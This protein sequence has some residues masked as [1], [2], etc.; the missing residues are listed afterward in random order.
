[1]KNILSGLKKKISLLYSKNK[2]LFTIIIA[3]FLVIIVCL[4]FY[5]KSSSKINDD[6]NQNVNSSCDLNQDYSS[7]VED[8]IKS[9]LLTL[10]EVDKASVMVVCS[11]SEIVEYKTNINETTSDNSSTKNE[12]VAYEK[13]GSKNTPIIVTTKNPK[14]VG[15]WII[16][17]SVSASTKLAIT[18][19]ICS[20]LNI[21]QDCINILQER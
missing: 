16:I 12:E 17:N 19:S 2:K 20:V 1:M 11:S 4:F 13:D 18:N 8:K 14:I 3:L 6:S 9:M 5:P 15:I 21:E 7:K 10:D